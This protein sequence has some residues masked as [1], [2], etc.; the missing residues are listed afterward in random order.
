[1]TLSCANRLL[2]ALLSV[3]RILDPPPSPCLVL[4]CSNPQETFGLY[5]DAHSHTDARNW[6]VSRSTSESMCGMYIVAGTDAM[7]DVCGLQFS[8]LLSTVVRL[9]SLLQFI[10]MSATE[11]VRSDLP[12]AWLRFQLDGGPAMFEEAGFDFKRQQL[13]R[14]PASVLVMME[15]LR[16]LWGRIRD[17]LSLPLDTLCTVAIDEAQ[18]LSRH[19]YTHEHDTSVSARVS[20]HALALV[21]VPHYQS[22]PLPDF[23]Q[24]TWPAVSIVCNILATAGARVVVCGTAISLGLHSWLASGVGKIPV[25][26]DRS[27]AA[28]GG[29]LRAWDKETALKFLTSFIALPGGGP[30]A[31][32]GLGGIAPTPSTGLGD[33]DISDIPGLFPCA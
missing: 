4:R 30:A 13:S 24:K 18:V 7:R 1:M 16:S 28:L 31:G 20:C 15:V 22:S 33:L 29:M 11:E 32:G 10:E 21:Y 8:V 9:A 17:C 27:V 3:A 6:E 19:Q 26:R 5:F 23:V 14:R 2:I 12:L 25:G